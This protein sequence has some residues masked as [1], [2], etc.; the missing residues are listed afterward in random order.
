MVLPLQVELVEVLRQAGHLLATQAAQERVLPQATAVAADLPQATQAAQERVLL[1]AT[2][3]VVDHPQDIPGGQQQAL[4]QATA[5]AADP[6]RVTRVALV[7]ELPQ[8][9]EAHR[10]DQVAVAA[11]QQPGKAPFAFCVLKNKPAAEIPIPEQVLT[12]YRVVPPQ[13]LVQGTSALQ[14]LAAQDLAAPMLPRFP[15]IQRSQKI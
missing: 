12:R 1:Q 3:V 5:V 15:W 6:L 9:T 8:D 13:P 11:R 10:V 2:A 4:L 7:Q 14:D